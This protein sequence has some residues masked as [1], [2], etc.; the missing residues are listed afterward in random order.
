MKRLFL[1]LL[2]ILPIALYTETQVSVSV[3][4]TTS[5][6]GEQIT[7]KFIIRTSTESDSIRI[8]Q[9]KQDF[10]FIKEENLKTKKSADFVTFEKNYKI[11]FFKTGDFS[12]GPFSIG[13]MKGD[14]VVEDLLSNTIPVNIR[15][16]LEESDKDIRPLREL[17]EI[18]GNPFYLLKYLLIILAAAGI[19]ILFIYLLRR[20]KDDG[21][22]TQTPLLPPDLE[23]LKKIEALW[24]TDLLKTGNFKR[25]FLSLTEAYKLFMTR[26]YKFNAEDLTTYEI[27]NYLKKYEQDE[28]INNNFE[29]VFL[30]SD[31]VKF[32]KYE[33][34]ED[35]IEK[36]RETLVKIAGTAGE[37]RKKKEEEE[38]SAPL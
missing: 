37:R 19:I 30:I 28:K 7:L 33:P 8:S 38:K 16:V 2:F 12:V 29:E 25:F 3:S 17:S 22:K 26:F 20:K 23:F 6:I 13:L 36:I 14:Q 35:E 34:S 31:L 10:E 27:I 18:E 11:S 9:G 32:A 4:S 24:R 21:N 5:T 15:S 1:I